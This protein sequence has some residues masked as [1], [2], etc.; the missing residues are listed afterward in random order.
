MEEVSFEAPKRG[1]DKIEITEE[2]VKKRVSEMLLLSD[3]RKFII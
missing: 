1:G 3:L 2:Y